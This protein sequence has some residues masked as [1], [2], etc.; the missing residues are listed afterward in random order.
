MK[1]ILVGAPLRYQVLLQ[2]QAVGED[3]DGS[4]RPIQF[5]SYAPVPPAVIQS[6]ITQIAINQPAAG[7]AYTRNDYAGPGTGRRS[8]TRA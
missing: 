2:L 1:I 6:Q 3:W 4:I 5:L 7:S 8:S